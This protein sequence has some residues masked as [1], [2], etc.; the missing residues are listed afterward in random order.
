M[1]VRD[2]IFFIF[3]WVGQQYVIPAT[4]LFLLLTPNDYIT[5]LLQLQPVAVCSIFLKPVPFYPTPQLS[6][7][8]PLLAHVSTLEGYSTTKV[9]TCTMPLCPMPLPFLNLTQYLWW[10][11]QVRATCWNGLFANFIQLFVVKQYKIFLITRFTIEGHL[12]GSWRSQQGLWFIRA[13]CCSSDLNLA[14]ALSPLLTCSRLVTS[15]G[16]N[17]PPRQKSIWGKHCIFNAA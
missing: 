9:R 5:R 14:W 11:K 12:V 3:D 16:I 15:Q 17:N 13:N 6:T 7:A 8:A 4:A 1:C 2:I 10:L